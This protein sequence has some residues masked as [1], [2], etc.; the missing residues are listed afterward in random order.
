MS[1]DTIKAESLFLSVQEINEYSQGR[2]ITIFCKGRYCQKTLEL[3]D[4]EICGIVDN[5]PIL[6]NKEEL[7]FTVQNPQLQKDGKHSY[8]VICTTSYTE[9]AAQLKAI[10]F[11]SED[12]VFLLYSDYLKLSNPENINKTLIFTSGAA[13]DEKEI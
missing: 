9:V 12:F 5:S 11:S 3:H 7:G 6:W 2:P 10:G 4:R 1:E 8:I 13:E